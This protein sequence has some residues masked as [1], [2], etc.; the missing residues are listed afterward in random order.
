MG[1]VAESSLV[2][3]PST[4]PCLLRLALSEQLICG[5][6]SLPTMATKVAQKRVS[7]EIMLGYETDTDERTAPEGS[8]SD[9]SE[10]ARAD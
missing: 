1:H 10:V 9:V 8:T 6:Y 2:F 4:G 5:G 3:W 7:A